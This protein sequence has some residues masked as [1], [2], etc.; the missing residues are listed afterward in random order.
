MYTIVI[1]LV[2]LSNFQKNLIAEGLKLLFLHIIYKHQKYKI[3]KKL[4]CKKV[5]TLLKNLMYNN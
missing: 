5:L 3:Y 1:N 2:V 4:N